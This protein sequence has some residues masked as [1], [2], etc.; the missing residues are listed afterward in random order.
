MNGSTRSW[1]MTWGPVPT[2]DRRRSGVSPNR[3]SFQV[4]RS[5][6]SVKRRAW[7]GPKGYSYN[8]LHNV[9]VVRH[10][11]ADSGTLGIQAILGRHGNPDRVQ[12]ESPGLELVH[13]ILAHADHHPDGSEPV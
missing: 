6:R 8:G 9:H 10:P 3:Q 5:V 12:R 2:V 13:G 1:G 7:T 11:P 4:I